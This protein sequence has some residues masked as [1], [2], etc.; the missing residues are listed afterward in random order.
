MELKNTVN[1][2]KNSKELINSRIFQVGKKKSVSWKTGTLK[3][4]SRGEEQ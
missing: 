2:M 3:L 4:S 1:E